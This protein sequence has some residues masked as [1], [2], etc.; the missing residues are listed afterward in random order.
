MTLQEFISLKPEPLRLGQFFWLCFFKAQ[1]HASN[2]MLTGSTI[3]ATN[4]DEDALKHIKYY[5]RQYQWQEL[6]ADL[7]T[8]FLE[9]VPV[10]K[11]INYVTINGETYS[12]EHD[13][14]MGNAGALLKEKYV[15]YI[16]KLERKDNQ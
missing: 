8:K 2:H 13:P 15:E 7:V 14:N 12:D 16:E 9:S 11:K 1:H 3:W 5:M 10:K 6:D 4:N